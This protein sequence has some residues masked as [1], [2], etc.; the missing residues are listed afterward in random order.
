[1]KLAKY[2]EQVKNVNIEPYR[3]YF[4]PFG[5]NDEYSLDRDKSSRFFSLNGEWQICD[6]PSFYDLPEDFLDKTLEKTISVP[7]CLQLNGF[8]SPQYTNQNYPFAFN[9]P[10]VPNINP[11]YHYRKTFDVNLDGDDKFLVFEGVDSCFYL[12]V[13]GQFVGYT[14]ISHKMS[15]FNIT[16]Y[17]VQGENVIDV[18]VLKWC[19]SSYLEDQDKFRFT[20]IF[21]DV[22]LLSRNNRAGTLQ[23]FC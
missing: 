18:I 11:T 5:V 7:S 4:V 12:L 23:S 3:C 16:K 17:L 20:G 13:N 9:P 21:R 15:E 22:Y 1:M 2:F 6:Y 10:Y 14:Q 19:A 8:D